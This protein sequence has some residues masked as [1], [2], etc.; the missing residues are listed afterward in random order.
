MHFNVAISWSV[1]THVVDDETL[2]LPE[3]QAGWV[4]VEGDGEVR[5]RGGH[6]KRAGS[7]N[8]LAQYACCDLISIQN[9]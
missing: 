6:L 8:K 1:L 5:G 7:P 2:S 3:D 9:G 4:W